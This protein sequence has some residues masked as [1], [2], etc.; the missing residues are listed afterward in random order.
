MLFISF[1]GNPLNC[2]CHIRP[3]F[4]FYRTVM[5]LPM[6]YTNIICNAPELA[7]NRPLHEINDDNLIC[8]NSTESMIIPD[9]DVL[10]D[11]IFQEIFL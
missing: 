1:T 10:P 8:T 11:L 2:D 7:A 9:L 5:D 3:L 6:S 4:H